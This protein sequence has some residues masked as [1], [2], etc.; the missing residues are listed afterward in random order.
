MERPSPLFVV[1]TGRCGSTMLSDFLREHDRVLSLSEFFCLTTDFGGRIAQAFTPESVDAA[2]LWRHLA[3]A[4]P[5]QSTMVRHGVGIPEMLYQPGP[6]TRF[7]SETGVPALMQT[8]LPHLSP[9]AEALFS[10]VEAF[11]AGLPPAPMAD[12]YARL[13]AW[14]TERFGKRIWVERSGGSLRIVRRLVQAFPGARFVHIVRDGRA[15][16]RSM[17]RHYGFRMAL[18]AMQLTEILGVDPYESSDRTYI[19]DVPD[20]LVPFLP[21][22]FDGEAFRRWETPLPLCGHYWSGE[23]RAGVRELASLPE[24]RVLTMRYEDFLADP[25]RSLSRLASFLGPEYVDDRWVRAA[26]SKIRPSAT[27]AESVDAAELR[28]LDDACR[29]G[30]AALAELYPEQAA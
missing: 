14:L 11:V 17:S 4:H 27:K 15:C 29:P 26:A 1:G 21:E 30:F 3:G 10:D 12:H 13:F 23:I 24:D 6:S 2:Q 19:G 9:D 5:K 22:A 8:T 28:A 18:I 20:D 7:S 25:E 16:A